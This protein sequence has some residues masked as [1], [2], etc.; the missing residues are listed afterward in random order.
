VLGQRAYDHGVLAIDED[1]L[2]VGPGHQR[3][4][5][6]DER[7]DVEAIELDVREQPFVALA[8]EHRAF[9]RHG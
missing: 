5:V 9:A 3:S 6:A 1:A 7:L 8:Q 2:C 4:I